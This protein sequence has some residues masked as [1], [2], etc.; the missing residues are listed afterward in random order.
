M[1]LLFD[2]NLSP[3]LVTRLADLFRVPAMYSSRGLDLMR[4]TAVNAT[5][6]KLGNSGLE[7]AP[8]AFGGNVFGWTADEATSFK[9]LDAFVAAGFNL[10]DTAD[11]YSRW[12]ARQP[13]RR[14][15]NDHRQ[16]AQ[17]PRQPRQG[18]HRH[19]GRHGDGPDR[20]GPVASRTSSAAVER[21]LRRLQTDHIDLYQAH[22][23][24][25]ARR[26][27]RPSRPSAS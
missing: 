26:W 17:A 25:E 12:V 1:K 7:V 22:K 11:V 10:I 20:Q 16:L 6:R 2:Q 14:I 3:N 18:D 13:G 8:L 5:R 23:D 9:L 27:K 21:S 24:D 19:Q 4:G 15:R